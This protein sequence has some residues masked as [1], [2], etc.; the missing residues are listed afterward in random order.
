M[1]QTTSGQPNDPAPASPEAVPSTRSAD[2]AYVNLLGAPESVKD[3]PVEWRPYRKWARR[4]LFFLVGFLPVG[5]VLVRL[6]EA[7]HLGSL[8]IYGWMGF[9][10][11]TFVQTALFRCPRCRERYFSINGFGSP[12]A[13]EC[14]HCG[15]PKWAAAESQAAGRP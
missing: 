15:L 7:L 12:L 2:G 5:G 3:C 10:G 9:G 14:M 1:S 4:R 11:F 13:D 6:G 8:P